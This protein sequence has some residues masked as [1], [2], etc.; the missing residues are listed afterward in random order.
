MQGCLSFHH[1]CKPELAL[2]KK[3][4]KKTAGLWFSIHLTRM[5]PWSSGFDASLQKQPLH[6]PSTLKVKQEDQEL[7]TEFKT[8]SQNKENHL[9][10][11]HNLPSCP[12]T[13][14]MTSDLPGASELL[15]LA[16]GLSKVIHGRGQE[17]HPQPHVQ[18]WEMEVTQDSCPL[19]SRS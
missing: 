10:K 13:G 3:N 8:L 9:L 12:V 14:P 7:M 11:R 6:N 4:K 18:V 5:K 1:S 16:G 15:K 19:S 17:G 2:K